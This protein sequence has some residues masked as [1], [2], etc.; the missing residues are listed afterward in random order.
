MTKLSM[1]SSKEELLKRI[2]ELEKQTLQEEEPMVRLIKSIQDGWKEHQK[3]FPL[4]IEDI[5]KTYIPKTIE[6]VR[7]QW[8]SFQTTSK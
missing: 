4:F 3:E 1:N 8:S 5:V 6:Y 2:D 7:G